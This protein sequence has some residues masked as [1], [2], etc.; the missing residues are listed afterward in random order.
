MYLYKKTYLCGSSNN[1]EIS[2][3]KNGVKQVIIPNNLKYFVEEVMYLRKANAIHKWFVENV[4]EGE[5]D[6][7]EYDVQIYKLKELL[8]L[9]EQ[10]KSKPDLAFTLLPTKGGFFFGNTTYDSE[11][12]EDIDYT[13][14]TLT[15]ILEEYNN[16]LN[17]SYVSYIYTSSW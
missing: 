8:D 15:S 7:G 9:C 4:Q 16:T 13:I 12:F 6:C 5:D 11:Y 14:N 10:V 2:L 3:E 17:N 1:A